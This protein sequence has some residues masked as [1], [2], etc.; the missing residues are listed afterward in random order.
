M[1]SDIRLDGDAVVIEG[2]W[3]KLLTW[4]LM[5]DGL[6]RRSA[7]DG[8]RRALVHGP[9][10]N[11]IVNFHRDY[12]GGVR[13][14]GHVRVSDKL[15]IGERTMTAEPAPELLPPSVLHN[16][17]N[18]TGQRLISAIGTRPP[19][20]VIA[21]MAQSSPASFDV[22]ASTEFHTPI[23]AA[24]VRL[25]SGDSFASL[26]ALLAALLTRIAGLEARVSELE[27]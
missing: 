6:G 4:D 17:S 10:D 13:L 2:K 8:E 24:D 25:P 9:D 14:E 12:P 3:T 19:D 15:T 11:L 1:V 18:L 20:R 27:T 26:N 16:L 22:H 7:P 5:L 23:R 21:T